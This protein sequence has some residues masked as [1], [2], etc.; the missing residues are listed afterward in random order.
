MAAKEKTIRLTVGQAIAKYLS[1]QYSEFDGKKQRIIPGIA[2]I[3]GHGNVCGL[4][5][6]VSEYGDMTYHQCR[7]EQSMVHM[8]AGFAKANNRLSTLACTSSIG[9]GATNMVTGAATA[10]ANR[11]PVLL[12]PGDYYCN[13]MQGPVLQQI[14]HPVSGDVSANDCFR[15]VSRFFDRILREDQILDALPEAMRVLTDP[16]DTG[17]VTIALP[18]DLQSYAFDYPVHFFE[19]RVWRIE[20]RQ[21]DAQRITE[22][23]AMMKKAK[24]PIVI[25]GGGVNYSDASAELQKFCEKFG[26]P[27]METSAGKGAIQKPTSLLMGGTGFNGTGCAGEMM[28][29]ADLVIAVGTRLMDF[30]TGAHTAF[31][32]PDVKFI[33]IN[34]GAKD[35]FKVGA[36][37]IVADA[38]AGLVALTK[39]ATKAE[40]KPKASHVKAAANALEAWEKTMHNK[41]YKGFKGEYPNMGQIIQAMNKIATSG[42]TIVAAAGLP[43]GDILKAW[44]ATEGKFAHLEFGFS[45]MTYEIPAAIGVALAQKTKNEVRVLIGDGTFLMLPTEIVTAVQEGLKLTIVIPENHGFQ[46]IRGLQVAMS[47][48]MFGTEFRYREKKEKRLEGDYLKLDLA[49][50][51]HGLGAQT[52]NV[53]NVNDLETALAEAKK[54]KGTCVIVVETEP[55]RNLPDSGVWADFA[56]SEVSN[57][58]NVNKCRDAYDKVRKTQRFYY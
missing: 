14:E 10:T 44:D 34:V 4:A 28:K 18:Q 50:V 7:H 11:L 12:L 13:R 25:A 57:D 8:A 39:A 22:A 45:C 38:K 33:G 37:P 23:V 40:I 56:P 17:A 15:P 20:R 43:P 6:G 52:W 2:G 53:D 49:E 48:E 31:Q 46:S 21:P 26:I 1:V 47:D 42:D 5:Q 29:S 35:A 41:S 16:A 32:D 55:H 3:F 58:P 36:L 51:A 19:E 30:T 54:A 24:R 27:V 9:P